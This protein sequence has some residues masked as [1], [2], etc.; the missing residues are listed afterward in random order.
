VGAGGLALM[1]ALPDEEI[2]AL[3]ARHAASY[4]HIRVSSPALM[5]AVRQTRSAGYS[6]IVDTITPGVSGVGVAFPVSELTWVAFSFGAISSRLDAPRRAQMGAL[7][8]AECQA[9]AKD[10]LGQDAQ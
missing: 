5:K 7:L 9:W 4:A 2:A 3:Y 1:A 10:Y 8:H 6:E